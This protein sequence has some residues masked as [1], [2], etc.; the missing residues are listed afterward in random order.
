MAREC[1][2]APVRKCGEGAMFASHDAALKRG[3]WAEGRSSADGGDE[4]GEDPARRRGPLR[5]GIPSARL[6]LKCARG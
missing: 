6:D 5:L 4:S 2:C 1:V 3:A